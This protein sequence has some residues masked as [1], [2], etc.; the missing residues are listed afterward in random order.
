MNAAQWNVKR[1]EELTTRELYAIMKARIDV[2]V[3][4]QECAYEEADNKDQYALHLYLQE[5]GRIIAYA[6]LLPAGLSYPEPSIGRVLVNKEYRRQGY[7]AR[8]I[9]KSIAYI[10]QE[11]GG[12][13]IKISAQSHLQHFYGLYGFE[14]S[15]DIYFED[16]IPHMEMVLLAEK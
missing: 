8:L 11:W 14:K 9:E 16:G 3:V 6:R 4:E 10:R 13:K 1:F 7:A 5:E 2:F 12:R 15:S